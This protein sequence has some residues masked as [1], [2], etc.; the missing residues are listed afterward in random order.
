MKIGWVSLSTVIIITSYE[1]LFLAEGCEKIKRFDMN[2]NDLSD[3]LSIL[4][5]HPNS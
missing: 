1:Q 3:P 5:G 4:M 2:P